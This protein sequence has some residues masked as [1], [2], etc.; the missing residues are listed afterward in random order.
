MF[1]LNG[2]EK[3][4][5]VLHGIT[6]QTG[7][8]RKL[9]QGSGFETTPRLLS[10]MQPGFLL[11]PEIRILIYNVGFVWFFFFWGLWLQTD[12]GLRR[13]KWPDGTLYLHTQQSNCWLI[14][15]LEDR[16]TVPERGRWKFATIKSLRSECGFNLHTAKIKDLQLISWRKIWGGFV[17]TEEETTSLIGNSETWRNWSWAAA[18]NVRGNMS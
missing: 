15:F 14:D 4:Q 10:E 8:P 7:Q 6:T 1:S 13:P 9:L 5:P 18:A 16:W 12:S 2:E 3:Q 11:I 17:F